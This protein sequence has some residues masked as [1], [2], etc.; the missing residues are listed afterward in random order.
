MKEEILKTI[1]IFKHQKDKLLE[2][3]SVEYLSFDKLNQIIDQVKKMD[4]I[5]KSYYFQLEG[6]KNENKQSI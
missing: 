5:L 3:M 2:N 6:I 4:E 1:N